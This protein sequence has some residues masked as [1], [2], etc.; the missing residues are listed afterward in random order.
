MAVTLVVVGGGWWEGEGGCWRAGR[1]EE[2]RGVSSSF[3][4]GS[5][6]ALIMT[7]LIKSAA[8]PL[9]PRSHFGAVKKKLVSARVQRLTGEEDSHCERI[10]FTECV[11][12]AVG[13]FGA[14]D[15]SGSFLKCQLPLIQLRI[16]RRRHTEYAAMFWQCDLQTGD[17]EEALSVQ[18]QNYWV[19]IIL[20]FSSRSTR[21][22]TFLRLDLYL[23]NP[24]EMRKK[25]SF[26]TPS[27]RLAAKNVKL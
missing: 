13:G 25:P 24:T 15:L 11:G 19:E 14:P 4:P 23:R 2:K 21:L 10:H 7:G 20:R 22:K 1:R 17:P 16:F 26:K 6:L 3:N 18:L 12:R 8:L 5:S 9:H 27:T